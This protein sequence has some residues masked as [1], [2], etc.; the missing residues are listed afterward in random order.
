MHLV[1]TNEVKHTM[2]VE[3]NSLRWYFA[4]FFY[5]MAVLAIGQCLWTA[6]DGQLLG[7]STGIRIGG[8]RFG[9]ISH[10]WDSLLLG[11]L[12]IFGLL[13]W[14][15]APPHRYNVAKESYLITAVALWA[16]AVVIS[17]FAG[18]FAGFGGYINAQPIGSIHFIIILGLILVPFGFRV[19]TPIVVVN[20]AFILRPGLSVMILS[21]VLVYLGK[22]TTWLIWNFIKGGGQGVRKAIQERSTLQPGPPTGDSGT[23]GQEHVDI[24]DSQVLTPEST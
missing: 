18:L 13:S 11:G 6:I 2:K 9:A 21:F 17:V 19:I 12:I 24:S 7:S 20:F 23:S 4:W 22:W 5:P 16:F 3:K 10:Y 14:K 15:F 8:Y 1:K